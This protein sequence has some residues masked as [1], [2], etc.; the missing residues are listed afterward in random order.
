MKSITS[1]KLDKILFLLSSGLS[2]RAVASQTGVSKSKVALINK[3]M[4]SDKENLLAGC[5]SKLSSTDKRA[6]SI[7]I[8]TGKAEN[9]V[10]VTKNINTILPQPVCVQTVRNALKQDDF[11][12]VVK[13]KKPYLSKKHRRARLAFALK[14]QEWT[15]EDWKHVIWSDETKINRFGSDGKQY[16]WKKKGQ[17]LLEREVAPT[18]KH[19]GG[20]IM[21][22]GCMSWNGVGTMV[23]VEGRMDAKQYVK[24]LEEGLLESIQNSNI[25]PADVI[26]QQ[27]NDPKHTSNLAT[28]FFNDQ[29]IDV[30]DWPAQSPDL[31][32]IEHLWELLKKLVNNHE[33]PP[34]GV[35]ELWE[36]AAENWSEITEEQC[37]A[38]IESMP[39][40]LEAVIRAKGQNTK[41]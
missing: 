34:S 33:H 10:Q 31:N 25:S 22:W 38:L 7:Q 28:N 4:G 18:V 21:V 16:V 41:Y 19:G 35:F 29:D 12:A 14:Y 20:N 23:E 5:P 37:Q 15:V 24:I 3:E 40:R 13:K 1:A 8:N 30:L 26:F 27:D 39:R 9:A 11:V 6:I 32:P 2:T 17:P 36:R